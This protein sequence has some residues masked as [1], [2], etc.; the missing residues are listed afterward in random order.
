MG[1]VGIMAIFSACGYQQGSNAWKPLE[2]YIYSSGDY[3]HNGHIC[4]LR[5]LSKSRMHESPLETYIYSN[6]DHWHS[7]HVRGLVFDSQSN[8]HNSLSDIKKYRHL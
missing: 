2:T 1:I 8:P 7:D 4:H 6:E 3:W 5:V